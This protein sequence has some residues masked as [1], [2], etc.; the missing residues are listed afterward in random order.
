MLRHIVRMKRIMYHHHILS[1]NSNETI[2]KI[3][4]KQNEDTLGGD[5]YS[6]LIEDLKFIGIEINEEEIQKTSKVEYKKKIKKLVHIAAFKEM[7][8]IKTGMK[9]VKDVEYQ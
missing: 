1:R 5:W 2:M 8:K 9:K 3:C 6:L 4:M 7:N